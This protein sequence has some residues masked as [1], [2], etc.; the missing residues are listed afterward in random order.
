MYSFAKD[1]L[2][3]LERGDEAA[4]AEA[5][6]A[7]EPLLSTIVQKSLPH[8]LRGRFDSTDIV[9]AVWINLLRAFRQHHRH[10]K[11]I[12]HLQAFL[13][14]ATRNNLFSLLRREGG[15]PERGG[16]PWAFNERSSRHV[17]TPPEAAQVD[18]LWDRMLARCPRDYRE[19]LRLRREGFSVAEVADR[20]G[21]HRR[22][23][24]RILN[25]LA[26]RI[27]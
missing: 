17:P 16:C 3:R 25:D 15:S 18:E 2:T 21:L 24:R 1:L 6:E 20:I 8:Y 14:T 12:G 4:I 13:I 23:V 9:Q 11:G 22:K 10:F 27:G 5:Y 19:I 7:Y 26:S